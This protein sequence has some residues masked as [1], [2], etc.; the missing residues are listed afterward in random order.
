MIYRIRRCFSSD[1]LYF[2]FFYFSDAINSS[3]VLL[4]D[5]LESKDGEL[6][7]DLD[8]DGIE[9]SSMLSNNCGFVEMLTVSLLLGPFGM[10][11][12]IDDELFGLER[13][14]HF[15]ASSLCQVYRVLL[16]S[17][18]YTGYVSIGRSRRMT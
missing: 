8:V 5:V 2:V 17:C 7:L 9:W 12:I 13:D 18:Q 1:G 16:L 14:G 15:H 10:W 6:I 4:N 11:Y 3:S